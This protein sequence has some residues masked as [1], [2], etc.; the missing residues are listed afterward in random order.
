[1]Q[2]PNILEWQFYHNSLQAWVVAGIVFVVIGTTLS[3]ARTLLARRLEK[4]AA[5][6]STTAPS[7]SP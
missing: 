3:I 2:A 5:R 6:T 7:Q 4:V 1:M